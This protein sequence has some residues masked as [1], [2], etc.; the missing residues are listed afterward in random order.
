MPHCH[1]TW[2]LEGPRGRTQP[3]SFSNRE[4]GLKG[5]MTVP[6]SKVKDSKTTILI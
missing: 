6:R 1:G 5:E 2:G 4:T 3:L